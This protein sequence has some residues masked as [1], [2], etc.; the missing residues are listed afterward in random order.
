[1]ASNRYPVLLFL[2]DTDAKMDADGYCAQGPDLEFDTNPAFS[3]PYPFIG[4]SPQCP[5]DRQWQQRV[6]A[7]SLTAAVQALLKAIPADPG[8]IYATGA[9][10]GGTAV[11]R[12]ASDMPG[13][14]AALAP[15]NAFEFNAPGLDKKLHDL[16]VRMIAG[17][18]I[19][20]AYDGANAMSTLLANNEP[21]L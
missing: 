2:H 19:G 9:G 15:I 7:R 12:L 10:M 11:W 13:C 20:G 5:K 16:P 3:K 8:R 17:V 14:F 4:I 6:I 18:K 21:K 1:N